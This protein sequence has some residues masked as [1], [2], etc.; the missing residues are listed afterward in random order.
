MWGCGSD[1]EFQQEVNQ[2]EHRGDDEW[3]YGQRAPREYPSRGSFY[4]HLSRFLL[5]QDELPVL[6]CARMPCV[7]SW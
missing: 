2:R 6:P 5:S 1:Q 3:G 4:A 7:Y